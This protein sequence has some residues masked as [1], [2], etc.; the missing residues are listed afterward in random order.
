MDKKE[1]GSKLTPMLYNSDMYLELYY[2]IKF[3]L[4]TPL[5][6]IGRVYDLIFGEMIL[7]AH[8]L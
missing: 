5:S 7:T 2:S 3:D 6:K 4:W 1:R 8:M